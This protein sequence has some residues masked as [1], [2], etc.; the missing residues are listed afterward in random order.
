M[1]PTTSTDLKDLAIRSIHHMAIGSRSEFDDLVHPDGFTRERRAAPPDARGT[2]PE[3][4]YRLCSWL[5]G[6][7]DDMSYE[8]HDV[9]AEAD[10]V[11]VYCTM[12]GRHTRPFAFFTDGTNGDIDV[13]AAFAPTGKTFAITESHWFHMCDGKIIEHWANRDDLGWARQLGWVPPN[14]IYLLRCARMK[15]QIRKSLSRIQ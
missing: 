14:P 3:A 11:T 2:G 6:G 13:D 8:I 15:R 4:L 1:A 10:T 5:R 12:H 9:I 7:F